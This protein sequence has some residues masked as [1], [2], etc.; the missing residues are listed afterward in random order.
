MV[1]MG[2]THDDGVHVGR[3][4]VR[5]PQ[6]GHHFSGRVTK[7]CFTTHS[8]IEQDNPVAEVY[9][10]DVLLQHGVADGQ[11]VILQLARDLRFVD[12]QKRRVGITER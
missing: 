8:G 7:Q 10:K 5:V 6:R 1:D 11:E 4:D 3:I 9:D 2:V 12:I